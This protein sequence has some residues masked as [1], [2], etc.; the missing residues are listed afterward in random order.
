MSAFGF[1]AHNPCN[2][3][4]LPRKAATEMQSLTPLEA[5][6]FLREAS[7]DR[8][9]ALFVLALATG[10]RPSEYLGLKWSDIDLEQGVINVQRSLHWRSYKTGDWYFGEPKTPRSSRRI[11]LPASVLRELVNHKRHQ[12]EERLKAGAEYK[13]LDLVSPQGK[14]SR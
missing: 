6:R 7:S 8:W 11:P 4:E 1:L 3:V 14:V 10:L 5:A 9:S 12:G 2:S 13:N